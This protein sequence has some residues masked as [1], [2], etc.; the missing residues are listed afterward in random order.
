MGIAARYNSILKEI[1]Y[2]H[3]GGTFGFRSLMKY[4]P[5][6]NA[7]YITSFNSSGVQRENTDSFYENIE[8]YIVQNCK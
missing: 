1:E 8:K 7:A 2:V 4:F 5:S 6:K 3:G